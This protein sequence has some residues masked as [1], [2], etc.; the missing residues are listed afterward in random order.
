[1]LN[2]MRND[3]GGFTLI[4][5]LVVILIVGILAAIA[6]PS[7]LGQQDKG[8]DAS[9]KSNAR[10]AVT[11]V[12]SCLANPN[13]AVADCD[14]LTGT[15]LTFVADATALDAADEVLVTVP[16]AGVYQIDAYSESGNTFTITKADDGTYART[17]DTDG[18]AGC[19]PNG[20]W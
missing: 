9:A 1:M 10:N 11:Q 16:T 13:T 2:R 12:D 18:D 7:F 17:C 14:A 6:L 5:L 15:G 4:E 20:E 3:E 8:K 19:P